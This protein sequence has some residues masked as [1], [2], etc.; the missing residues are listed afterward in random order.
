MAKRRKPTKEEISAARALLREKAN[1]MA[2]TLER[3]ARLFGFTL[4]FEPKPP[5]G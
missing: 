5:S 1:P 3:I 2:E 4:G